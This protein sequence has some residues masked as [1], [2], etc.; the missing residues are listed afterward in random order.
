MEA[1]DLRLP[2]RLKLMCMY[3]K[4]HHPYC[5]LLEVGLDVEE[6]LW[7]VLFNFPMESEMVSSSALISLGS[8]MSL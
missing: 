8:V 2:R 5:L 4:R 7:H 1:V 3:P 6:A